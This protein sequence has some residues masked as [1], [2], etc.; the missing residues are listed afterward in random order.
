M[1]SAERAR[2]IYENNIRDIDDAAQAQMM[3]ALPGVINDIENRAR[4]GY[5]RMKYITTESIHFAVAL[6]KKLKQEGFTIQR[7]GATAPDK[8]FIITW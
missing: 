3:I 5:R 4:N 7:D 8:T 2:Q 1:T 6:Q